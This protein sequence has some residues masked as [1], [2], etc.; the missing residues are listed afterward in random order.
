MDSP[1]DLIAKHRGAIQGAGAWPAALAK[2]A[3]E[4][5]I[6]QEIT[7]NGKVV[8]PDDHVGPV[9]QAVAREV[10]QNPG[11]WPGEDAGHLQQRIQPMGI[12]SSELAELHQ[13]T[14][15]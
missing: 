8:I 3:T 2:D 7:R 14:Q 9:R 5:Q 4:G 15:K 10:V 1:G 11:R 13:Q 12:R 6:L